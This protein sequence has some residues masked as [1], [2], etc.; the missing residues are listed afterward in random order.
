MDKADNIQQ[1]DLDA[2]RARGV[3]ALLI[4]ADN[5]L[6]RWNSHE[7]SKAVLFWLDLAKA[8]GFLPIIVSNASRKRLAPLAARFSI[9]FQQ[10]CNKPLPFGLLRAARQL[11]V[12]RRECLMI[13]DQLITDMTAGWLAGMQIMLVNPIDPDYEYEGTKANRRVERLLK[14]LFRI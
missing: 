3:K 11:G 7:V 13:G 6:A 8:K 4:D 14:K 10:R 2:L 5:T 1:I 9:P 12:K